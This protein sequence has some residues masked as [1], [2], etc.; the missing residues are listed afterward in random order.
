MALHIELPVDAGDL[1]YMLTRCRNILNTAGYA[2]E[3]EDINKLLDAYHITQDLRRPEQT[4]DETEDL[5]F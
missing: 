5:P 3:V 2:D 4:Q 1:I